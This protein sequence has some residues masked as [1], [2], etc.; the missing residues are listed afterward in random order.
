MHDY[1]AVQSLIDRLLADTAGDIVEVRIRA[2]AAYSPEALEQAYE[3]LTP[4]TPLEGSRLVVAD[5]ADARPCPACG[6]SWTPTRDA[7]T[8]PV[9]VCPS[10]GTPSP[11]DGGTGDASASATT[12]DVIGVSR[13]S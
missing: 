7:R 12:V 10:C 2:G 6:A 13:R 11:N 4:G 8:M 3:M 9:L 1:H 5:L